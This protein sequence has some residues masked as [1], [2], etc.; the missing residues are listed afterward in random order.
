MTALEI[1]A[2][3]MTDVEGQ[4][5]TKTL[6]EKIAHAD[7]MASVCLADANR[8][9]EAGKPSKAARLYRQAQDWLDLFNT[10]RGDGA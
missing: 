5:D 10:L 6:A 7:Y 1:Q 9:A 8:A 2:A 3:D 4:L